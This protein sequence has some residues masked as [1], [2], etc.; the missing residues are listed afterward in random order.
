MIFNFFKL[1]WSDTR[2]PGRVVRKQIVPAGTDKSGVP[3][4]TQSGLRFESVR[5]EGSY[6]LVLDTGARFSVSFE[7]FN[8]VHEGDEFSP[9][10]A[11][12]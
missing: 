1:M 12:A 2:K 9:G 5:R 10:M 4:W 6:V 11:T 3:R 8:S 7:V